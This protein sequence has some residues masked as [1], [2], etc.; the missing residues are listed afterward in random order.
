MNICIADYCGSFAEN[1]DQAR[2]LREKMIRPCLEST[3]D[4]IVLDFAGVD[5]S[6]QSFVHA[7]ISGFFQECGE[8]AL[9][10][11]EFKNCSK[12]I[13]SLLATVVNYSLD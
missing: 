11:F 5:S 2:E 3:V 12:A 1:K 4:T 10:R 9:S 7:L 6:T 13:K 8:G